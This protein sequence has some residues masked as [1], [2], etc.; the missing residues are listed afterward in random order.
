MNFQTVKR[1][2]IWVALGLLVIVLTMSIAGNVWR[3]ANAYREAA[4]L[5]SETALLSS[6]QQVLQVRARSLSDF[7]WT[8]PVLAANLAVAREQLDAAIRTSFATGELLHLNVMTVRDGVLEARVDWRGS[9]HQLRAAL[10]NLAE[11]QP[12]LAVADLTLRAFDQAGEGDVAVSAILG[13]AW[14]PT[15]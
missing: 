6:R 8:Q 2:S 1:A 9:E 5:G 15:L 3:A 11:T 10:E 7:A 14:E 12:R 4:I 13:Q